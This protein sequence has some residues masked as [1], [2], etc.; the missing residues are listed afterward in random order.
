MAHRN[1][2]ARTGG[3]VASDRREARAL[4]RAVTELA[5]AVMFRD[6]TT[7]CCHD[8][9]VTQS[10]ALAAIV[11]RDK[12]TQNELAAELFLDKSTTS[13]L[14]ASLERLGYV[15]RTVKRG[16]ARAVVLSPTRKGRALHARM[17]REDESEM[18]AL[19]RDLPPS[20]R[21]DAARLIGRIARLV[22][23]GSS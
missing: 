9:S 13:R 11:R 5:R 1:G 15:G 3:R 22:S 7:V 4:R 10:Y 14:V 8:V 12:M 6:R 18:A 17:A 2:G 21:R 23:R 16:D 19:M 20:S